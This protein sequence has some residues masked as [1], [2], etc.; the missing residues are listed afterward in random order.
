MIFSCERKNQA[1]NTSVKSPYAN[2]DNEIAFVKVLFIFADTARTKT[3][4]VL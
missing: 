2:V 3:C 1:A 4:N